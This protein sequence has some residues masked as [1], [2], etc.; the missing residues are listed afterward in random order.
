MKVKDLQAELQSKKRDNNG[1][2]VFS[3]NDNKYYL[4]KDSIRKNGRNVVLCIDTRENIKEPIMIGEFLMYLYKLKPTLN[5]SVDS[6]SEVGEL[7]MVSLD[8]FEIYPSQC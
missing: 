6:L 4:G 7:S 5:I 3:L 8:E 2:L 1:Y